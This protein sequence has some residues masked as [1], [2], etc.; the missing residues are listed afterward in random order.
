MLRDL[1][2]SQKD[3]GAGIQVAHMISQT[4]SDYRIGEK[5]AAGNSCGPT[6]ESRLDAR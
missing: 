3:A 4:I 1:S 2:E 5:R 6:S